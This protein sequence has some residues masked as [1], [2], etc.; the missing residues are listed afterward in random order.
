MVK[1]DGSTE[2]NAKGYKKAQFYRYTAEQ[3]ENY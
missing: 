1:P 3:R 2:N